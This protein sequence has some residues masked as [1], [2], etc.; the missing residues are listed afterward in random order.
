M[1]VIN[2]ISKPEGLPDAEISISNSEYQPAA[3]LFCN[4]P[5]I[6]E[7]IQEMRREVLDH[8]EDIMTVGEVPFTFDPMEVRRYVEPER[9]ELCML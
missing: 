7:Y 9:G 5:H 6:H 1:D 2:M 3:A 8:Y 4:G